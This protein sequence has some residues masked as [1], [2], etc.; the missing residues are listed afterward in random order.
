M[1]ETEVAM[2]KLYTLLGLC[3]IMAMASLNVPQS[4]ASSEATHGN[5]FHFTRDQV[6]MQTSILRTTNLVYHAG[7]SVQTANPRTTY[8]IYWGSDFS[9]NGIPGNAVPNGYQTLIDSF[10]SNVAAD[11]SKTSNVYASDTQYYQNINAL[12]TFI[13]YSETRGNSWNDTSAYPAS[14]CTSTAG[15]T[16]A[17]L[18]DPQIQAEVAKAIAANG[19]PKGL[20]AEYF[21]FLPNGVST[22]FGTSCFVSTF[23][24]YHSNYVDSAS[25]SHVLYANMPF[26]GHKLSSCSGAAGSPNNN[27]SADATIS[28]LSHEANE[29]ITDPLGN[30]WYDRRGY[31]NGDKCAYN[32]G[33]RL[34][35]I[36]GGDYNQNIGTGHYETQQEWSNHSSACVLTG[37]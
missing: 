23:C 18:S 29:T 27:A 24:A 30:A 35:V 9:Y 34:G 10:F 1:K 4:G 21:V 3:S 15:G 7:G 36:N 37:Q 13:P 17:C 28:T 26:T 11:S 25:G 8:A 6:G 31:E 32:Y 33:T 5:P 20:A 2:R 22:C 14:G 16:V 12:Q 19:W